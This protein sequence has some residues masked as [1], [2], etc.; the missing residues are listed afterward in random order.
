MSA[1]LCRSGKPRARVTSVTKA[2]LAASRKY[3]N[4]NVWYFRQGNN[5][6]FVIGGNANEAFSSS[7]IAP[8]R[9]YVEYWWYLNGKK[10]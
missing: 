5:E 1:K 9:L 6:C 8:T 10:I 3:P 2:A 7:C 4:T